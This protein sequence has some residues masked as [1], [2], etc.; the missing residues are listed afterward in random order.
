MNRPVGRAF[1]L[2]A[3][4]DTT[5]CLKLKFSKWGIENQAARCGRN[6]GYRQNVAH[7]GSPVP[8]CRFDT[9]KALT[10]RDDSGM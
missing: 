8:Q 2:Q 7:N 5:E 6:D 9:V 3:V 1:D 10:L 4:V